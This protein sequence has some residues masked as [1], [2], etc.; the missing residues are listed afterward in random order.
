[1]SCNIFHTILLLYPIS[2]VTCSYV[3]DTIIHSL[4]EWVLRI[5]PQMI[6]S[7]Y[8]LDVTLSHSCLM[9]RRWQWQNVS[10]CWGD[11]AHCF[12]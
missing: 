8:K 1:M 11:M 6:L 2:C 12:Q 3:P 9:W 10:C 4:Q 5:H 7:L